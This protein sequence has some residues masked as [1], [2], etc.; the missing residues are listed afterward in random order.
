MEERKYAAYL[1]KGCGIG[2]VINFAD[3][4]KVATREANSRMLRSMTS[5]AVPKAWR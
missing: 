1:C 4:S 5:C 3:L 2:K